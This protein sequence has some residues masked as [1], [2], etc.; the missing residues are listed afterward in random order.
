MRTVSVAGSAATVTLP[1]TPGVIL[2]AHQLKTLISFLIRLANKDHHSGSR[3]L[4][5]T[6]KK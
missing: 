1:R 5:G 6:M 2:L 4:I 3:F